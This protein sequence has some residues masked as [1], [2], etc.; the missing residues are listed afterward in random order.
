M[1]STTTEE[2][3]HTGKRSE[4]DTAE[5]YY[6][7]GYYFIGKRP[8]Y[9]TPKEKTARIIKE[10][11]E[12]SYEETSIKIESSDYDEDYR[13][14]G[15]GDE[16]VMLLCGALKDNPHINEIS[17]M[18]QNV[19]DEGAK[20]LAKIS[21]LKDIFIG[22]ENIT[23]LGGCALAQSELTSLS[24]YGG[25]IF[26]NQEDEEAEGGEEFIDCLIKNKTIEKLELM[27]T[28]MDDNLL[29]KLI[30]NTTTIKSLYLG[31]KD[32]KQELFRD[33]HISQEEIHIYADEEIVLFGETE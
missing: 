1:E 16:E 33:L 29:I 32:F 25:H 23:A 2:H 19:G 14:K 5:G 13:E 21:A 9:E 8:K 26:I 12:G 24:I 7:E 11:N 15:I 18:L 30:E 28:Y 6:S 31:R 22:Y 10:L 20:A 27:N 3:Y 17:L 4:Y